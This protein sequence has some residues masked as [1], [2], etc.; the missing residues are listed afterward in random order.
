M[1]QKQDLKVDALLDSYDVADIDSRS[2]EALLEKIVAKASVSP[3]QPRLSLL[4]FRTP[5]LMANI[6]ALTAVALLGFWIGAGSL[7]TTIS[8]QIATTQQTT[9]TDAN[10]LYQIVFGVKSWKEVSL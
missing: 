10:Y 9:S 6:A 4:R 7:K 5:N 2:H 8:S 3:Q 1:T